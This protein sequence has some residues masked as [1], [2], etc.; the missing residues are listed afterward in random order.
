MAGLASAWTGKLNA[1]HFASPLSMSSISYR[2]LRA[3]DGSLS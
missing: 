1:I 2:A 3:E